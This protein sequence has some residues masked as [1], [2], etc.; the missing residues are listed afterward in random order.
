MYHRKQQADN[1]S[2]ITGVTRQGHAAEGE[3]DSSSLCERS[4]CVPEGW[5]MPTDSY[6]V[7]RCQKNQG[8]HERHVWKVPKV[9]WL[10][11]VTLSSITSVLVR[12]VNDVSNWIHSPTLTGFFQ[13][14]SEDRTSGKTSSKR[15]TWGQTRRNTQELQRAQADGEPG[16]SQRERNGSYRERKSKENRLDVKEMRQSFN[17]S[18]TRHGFSQ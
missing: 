1:R 18:E 12:G 8:V 16:Y 13:K 17:H 4:L 15:N 5:T 3:L 6:S 2:I 7:R 14:C 10:F 11:G 9:K